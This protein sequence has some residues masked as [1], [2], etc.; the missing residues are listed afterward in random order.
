MGALEGIEHVIVL[1]LENRSFDCM[2]GELYPKSASF[3]GLDGSEGNPFRKPDG[4]IAT[5]RVWNDDG[6][7]TSMPSSLVRRVSFP[8]DHR[9]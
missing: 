6:M 5:V 2:F 4:T 7:P 8:A 1:M 3:E 9:R